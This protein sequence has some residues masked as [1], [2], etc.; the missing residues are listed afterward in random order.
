M[1]YG[2]I[3]V[4]GLSYVVARLKQFKFVNNLVDEGV[5]KFMTRKSFIV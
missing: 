4:C 5:I 3:L 1:F 2:E